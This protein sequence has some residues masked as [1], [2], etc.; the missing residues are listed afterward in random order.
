MQL[1]E[2]QKQL[3]IRKIQ[4]AWNNNKAICPICQ[5][6][7]KKEIAGI[8]ELRDY[9]EGDFIVGGGVTPVVT[10]ICSKCGSTHF[11]NAIKLGIVDKSTGKL[12]A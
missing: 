5:E 9:H 11:F 2:A 10:V 8:M 6:I 1:S 4:A 3:I 7:T 12:M